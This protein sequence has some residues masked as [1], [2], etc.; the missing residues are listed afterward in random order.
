MC[1]GVL[2]Y[3]GEGGILPDIDNLNSDKLIRLSLDKKLQRKPH[4]KQGPTSDWKH[5]V[6][7][8]EDPLA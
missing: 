5:H 3:T 6:L 2:K 4:L 1:M 7:V 8:A